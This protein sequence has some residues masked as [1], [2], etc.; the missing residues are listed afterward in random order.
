VYEARAFISV[1]LNVPPSTET[2]NFLF[3]RKYIIFINTL[4]KYKGKVVLV[5]VLKAYMWWGNTIS[6]IN[7]FASVILARAD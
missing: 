3:D 5:C 2:T 6:G 4:I 7:L 1:S